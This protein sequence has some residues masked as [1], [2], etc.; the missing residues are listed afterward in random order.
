[1]FQHQETHHLMIHTNKYKNIRVRLSSGILPTWIT[2][3]CSDSKCHL[4]QYILKLQQSTGLTCIFPQYTH[5]YLYICFSG[6]LEK[7]SSCQ[8]PWLLPAILIDLLKCFEDHIKYHSRQ[9]ASWKKIIKHCICSPGVSLNIFPAGSL[10][11]QTEASGRATLYLLLVDSIPQ[12]EW[13][14]PRKTF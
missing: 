9:A 5:I 7:Y 8:L 13:D 2:L 11:C 4:F 3:Q 1:M 6:A 14:C 10:P 12:Q